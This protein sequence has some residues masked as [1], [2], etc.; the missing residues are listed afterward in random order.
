MA[1][2]LV[3]LIDLFFLFSFFFFMSEQKY[4]SEISL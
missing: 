4:G 3:I 2:N 1:K